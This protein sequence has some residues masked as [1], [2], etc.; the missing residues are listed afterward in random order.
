MYCGS[1]SERN[2]I[3]YMFH[4]IFESV[5]RWLAPVL[6]FTSEEAYSCR[7]GE[8]SELESVHLNEFFDIEEIASKFNNLDEI[9]SRWTKIREIRT[10]INIA[11][12]ESRSAG[13]ISASLQ[14]NIEISCQK[15]YHNEKWDI[16]AI[17]SSFKCI[18]SQEVSVK[19]NLADGVKCERCWKIEQVN[20]ISVCKRCEKIIDNLH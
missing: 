10:A 13:S 15:E 19:V 9:K 2:K 6:V 1:E 7:Y 8:N 14:A 17:V 18:D 20:N 3:K 4:I 11:L 5:V 12:E 16:I